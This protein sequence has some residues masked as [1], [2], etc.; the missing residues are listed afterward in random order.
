MCV[1]E[2]VCEHE[3]EWVCV[4]ECVSVHVQ[5]E[6]VNMCTHMCVQ[7]CVCARTLLCDVFSQIL[8]AHNQQS[9][10]VDCPSD[11]TGPHVAGSP[12]G[13]RLPLMA[14]AP[15]VLIADNAVVPS[16]SFFHI[17]LQG[18]GIC[19]TFQD[20]GDEREKGSK[21]RKRFHPKKGE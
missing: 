9:I 8:L 19:N 11:V 15:L 10:S 4:H 6:N 20:E 7:V 13:R 1:C 16:F 12:S 21:G 18:G 2:N 5:C 17:G 3:G 14:T